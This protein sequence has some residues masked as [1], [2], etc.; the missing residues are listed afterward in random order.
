MSRVGRFGT[1]PPAM[2]RSRLRASPEAKKKKETKK[3]E[4][5]RCAQSVA[6]ARTEATDEADTNERCEE[7]KK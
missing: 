6:L 1:S 7:R 3:T 5:V 2:E 4:A